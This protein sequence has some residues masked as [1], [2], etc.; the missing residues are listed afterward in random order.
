MQAY[1][2]I[3]HEHKHTITHTYNSTKNQNTTHIQQYKRPAIQ[4]HSHNNA[5]T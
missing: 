5:I 1:N 4:T 2:T 3:V